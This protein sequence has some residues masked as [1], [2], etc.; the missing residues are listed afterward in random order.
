MLAITVAKEIVIKKPKGFVLSAFFAYLCS[1]YL[2]YGTILQYGRAAKARDLLH[3]RPA[4]P[5]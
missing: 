3:H 1:K 5:V 4:E 2:S